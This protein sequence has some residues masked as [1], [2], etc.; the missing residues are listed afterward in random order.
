MNLKVIPAILEGVSNYLYRSEDLE[1][2]SKERF[3][4]CKNCPLY[5]STDGLFN[6]TNSK[7]DNDKTVVNEN[8]EQIQGCG[9]FLQIKTRVPNES[10]PMSKWNKVLTKVIKEE[11]E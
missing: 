10:C 6:I 7:C 2:L 9:C 5:T 3:D 1:E 4:I 8:G 11:K